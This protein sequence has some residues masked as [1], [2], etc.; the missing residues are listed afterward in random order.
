MINF[1]QVSSSSQQTLGVCILHVEELHAQFAPS[2][3]V[4]RLLAHITGALLC[5]H[6]RRNM[7][8]TPV[9]ALSVRLYW[10]F[11]KTNTSWEEDIV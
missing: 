10:S 8:Q 1:I 9:F 5:L 4:I 7:R 6:E 2:E 3:Y 11:L